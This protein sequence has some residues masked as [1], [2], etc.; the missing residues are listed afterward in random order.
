MTPQQ[1]WTAAKADLLAAFGSPAAFALLGTILAYPFHT[2][3]R[4]SFTYVPAAWLHGP[5][6]SGKTLLAAA[7]HDFYHPS[8]DK[9]FTVANSGSPEAISRFL[10]AYPHAPV[11]LDEW[12]ESPPGDDEANDPADH[13]KRPGQKLP[14]HWKANSN[15]PENPILLAALDHGEIQR[16][17]YGTIS[18][19]TEKLAVPIICGELPSFDSDLRSRF[20]HFELPRRQTTLE[21]TS[22]FYQLL[23][24]R[25]HYHLILPEIIE[26]QYKAIASITR[27]TRNF[28]PA[29]S[30]EITDRSRWDIAIAF[31]TFQTIDHF[32]DPTSNDTDTLAAWLMDHAQTFLPSFA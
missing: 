3:L 4:A 20:L 10:A 18:Y 5:K 15:S 16:G 21:A 27:H 30:S 17:I 26:R 31:S 13:W 24:H 19:R 28:A 29:I 1:S 2:A 12:R 22:A 14:D 6:A 23:D 32:I 8:P 25:Q 11:C 7:I 9:L